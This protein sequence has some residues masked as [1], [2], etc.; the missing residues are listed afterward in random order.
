ME[1]GVACVAAIGTC[2]CTIALG[3]VVSIPVGVAITVL[4]TNDSV[5]FGQSGHG[6]LRA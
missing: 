5:G 4:P 6:E 3:H 2:W 1:K